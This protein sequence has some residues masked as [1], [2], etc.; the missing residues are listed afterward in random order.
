MPLPPDCLTDLSLALF[1]PIGADVYLRSGLSIFSED[2][3]PKGEYDL[4][5]RLFHYRYGHDVSG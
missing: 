3:K 1:F 5:V 2:A 4:L